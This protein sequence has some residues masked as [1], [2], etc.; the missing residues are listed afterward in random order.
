[1]EAK[2]NDEKLGG[3]DEPKLRSGD[4]AVPILVK[5]FESLFDLL[6]AV[7][8]PD[9]SAHHRQE[10]GEVDLAVSVGVDL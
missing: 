5:D 8:V 6:L 10:L 1:M 7:G 9:L 3:E 4:E 2:Q